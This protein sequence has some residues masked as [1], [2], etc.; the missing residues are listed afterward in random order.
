MSCISKFEVIKRF[1][2][3][4]YVLHHAWFYSHSREHRT[5]LKSIPSVVMSQ[6]LIDW[7]LLEKDIARR[8][9]G[10]TL[11]EEFFATGILRHSEWGEG[12][13]EGEREGGREGR[14]E[15]GKEE[16]EGGRERG[17]EGRREGKSE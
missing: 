14:R 15:G 17:R 1:P 5:G 3:E 4:I 2:H 6:K 8:V 13:K 10:V 9:D 16:G 7:W 11:G 12:G